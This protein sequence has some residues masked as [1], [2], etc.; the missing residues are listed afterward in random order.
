[1]EAA[2]TPQVDHRCSVACTRAGYIALIFSAVGFSLLHPLYVQS[3]DEALGQY[4]ALRINLSAA[5]DELKDDACWNDLVKHAGNNSPEDLP[6]EKLFTVQCRYERNHTV[7]QFNTNA[8]PKNKATLSI[9]MPPKK[10]SE[11][12]V[13]DT[14]PP[15]A[16]TLSISSPLPAFENLENTM[17][18]LGNGKL[19]TMARKASPEFDY[20]IFRW[21]SLRRKLGAATQGKFGGHQVVLLSGTSD[22]S[23][24]NFVPD[25]SR[26]ALKK[27]FTLS[28]IRKLAAYDQPMLDDLRK[29]T[30]DRPSRVSIPMTPIPVTTQVAATLV[31]GGLLASLVYFWL[32][33]QEAQSSKTFPFAGTLFSA[34]SRSRGSKILF[35]LMIATPAIASVLLALRSPTSYS[36]YAINWVMAAGIVLCA[37]A[38]AWT[39]RILRGNYSQ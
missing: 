21:A 2:D 11:K 27:T 33:Q 22:A 35:G 4:V 29:A 9:E 5:L 1:M 34:F 7:A 32:F 20:S 38:I 13:P 24:P 25:L 16:P 26:D 3:V 28:D 37:F 6:L 18:E 8:P 31:E 17:T 39:S 12:T 10:T 30:M 14:T 19:L 23:D 36:S 15:G